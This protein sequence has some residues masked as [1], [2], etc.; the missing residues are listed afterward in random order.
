MKPFAFR[1]DYI[2]LLGITL[3]PGLLT[4][5]FFLIYRSNIANPVSYLIKYSILT[6]MGCRSL[7]KAE[8]TKETCN[9]ADQGALKIIRELGLKDNQQISEDDLC[10][11]VAALYPEEY[12]TKLEA[13]LNS[14]YLKAY[15]TVDLR[16]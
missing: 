8:S 14:K 9:D 12:Q 15:Y 5:G 2:S 16:I 10:T 4:V 13:L 7:K 1:H 6:C 3:L 11:V